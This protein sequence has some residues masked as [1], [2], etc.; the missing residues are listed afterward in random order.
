VTPAPINDA[1]PLAGGACVTIDRSEPHR[2]LAL[3]RLD[4]PAHRNA[5]AGT[6]DVA[7]ARIVPIAGKVR[8][9]VYDAI[10][11]RG[12]EGLTDAEGETA[13]GLR[14]QSYTPRRN[15]LVRL[16]LVADSGRRR[17]TPSNR[18]AA[19]WI[20]TGCEGGAA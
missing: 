6:S 17:R 19:V 9:R 14:S 15:E 7:A 13:L 16:G 8:R 20:A 18:P 10:L 1:A 12:P 3:A 2:T 11:A 5:P 4:A